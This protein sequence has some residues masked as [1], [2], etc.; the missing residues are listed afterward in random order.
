MLERLWEER[1]ERRECVCCGGGVVRG[2]AVRYKDIRGRGGGESRCKC[3][4]CVEEQ[5]WCVTVRYSG[6][7]VTQLVP[8]I[9]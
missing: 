1:L 7:S 4:V 6:G 3:K 8:L 2:K 9:G 5:V